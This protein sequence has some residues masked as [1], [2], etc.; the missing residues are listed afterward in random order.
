MAIFYTFN[1][2]FANNRRSLQVIYFLLSL[3]GNN[4]SDGKISVDKSGFIHCR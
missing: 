2:D 3:N 4:I 1:T